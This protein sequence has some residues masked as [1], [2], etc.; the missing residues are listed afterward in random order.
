MKVMKIIRCIIVFSALVMLSSCNDWLDL[1]PA[2][3]TAETDLFETGDGYRN[4]LNGIYRQMATSDMYGK[5]LSWGELDAMSQMYNLSKDYGTSEYYFSLYDYKREEIYATIQTIWSK[6]YNSIANCNNIIQRLENES[7]SKFAKGEDEVKLIK[8]EALALRALL[9]FDILRLFTPCKDD[10]IKH[11]PYVTT[12]PC[13]FQEYSNN[14]DILEKIRED[15]IQAKQLVGEFDIPRKLWFQSSVRFENKYDGLEEEKPT[16]LFFAYRGYRLNYYAICGLLSRAYLYSGMY[17]E[18]FDETEVILNLY[19]YDE[20]PIDYYRIFKFSATYEVPENGN[21]KFY[22]DI[23]FCLSN[24]KLSE[25]YRNYRSTAKL[26]LNTSDPLSD[27]FNEDGSD[28]RY[29][30]LSSENYYYYCN[31]NLDP[32]VGTKFQFAKDMLPIIRL[33]ELY[34][35]RAE[36]FNHIKDEDSA[37]AEITKI[38]E[39][40]GCFANIDRNSTN[41][42][43]NAILDEARRE[44][45]GEGQLFYYYKRLNVL[46]LGMSKEEQFTLP[47]PQNEAL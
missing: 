8:G 37:A 10:N 22:D 6:A 9:H 11:M 35:I 28:V 25:D 41:W 43:I 20:Y 42:F 45:M 46:P 21:T 36:Y 27:W 12:Y 44:F 13:T 18:A 2:D 32:G 4:A 15:L 5:T 47:L 40:R 31:K 30:Q 19:V 26:Y 3:T 16:D 17:K 23:L 1:Q 24:Q 14:H 7:P 29:K 33:S 39:G 38:R 34:L